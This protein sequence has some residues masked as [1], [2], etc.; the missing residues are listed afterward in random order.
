MTRALQRDI[1]E[2]NLVDILEEL[3]RRLETVERRPPTIDTFVGGA[4]AA[5][6]QAQLRLRDRETGEW[7]TLYIESIDDIPRL[8]IQQIAV[9]DEQE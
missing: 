9:E 3:E 8:F 2:N 4:N 6:D 1:L 7:F 5:V